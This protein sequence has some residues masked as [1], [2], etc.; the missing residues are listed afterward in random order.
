MRR[1]EEMTEPPRPS[2]RGKQA[3]TP[4]PPQFTRR[5]TAAVCV[6][7]PSRLS[8]G[9]GSGAIRGKGRADEPMRR[10]ERPRERRADE[11]M[12]TAWAYKA[13]KQDGPRGGAKNEARGETLRR[14]DETR[15]GKQPTP[16]TG[17]CVFI[18]TSRERDE[19]E[20]DK[21]V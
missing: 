6:P 13:S 21:A 16:T 12:R 7:A 17:D 1:E 5:P 15:G 4:Q 18:F 8:N 2:S 10:D 9:A 20:G 14:H 11:P 19:S 3:A